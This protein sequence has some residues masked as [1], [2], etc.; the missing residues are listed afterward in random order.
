MGCGGP[1]WPSTPGDR[2]EDTVH[3]QPEEPA[4]GPWR[5]VPLPDLVELVADAGGAPEGRPLV[6]AIDGRGASGKSTLAAALHRHV[7]ASAVVHTDDLAWHEPLFRWG[8]LLA[9]V[10]RRLRQ[11]EALSFRPPTWAERGRDGAIEVPAGLDLVVVEGTGA[12]QREYADLV[13]VTVWVQADF[14]EAER[15]GIARDVEQGVNG[16]PEEAE[17]FW[18]EWMFEEL[19]FIRRQRPWERA[20]AIVH[21]SPATL[22]ADHVVVADPPGRH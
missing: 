11:G 15:R 1:G 22:P 5:T 7:A 16:G 12:S 8:H 18:H 14:A 21:G 19:Q 20:C 4:A 13:D 10:L 3:L 9:D 17:A 2:E 6:L